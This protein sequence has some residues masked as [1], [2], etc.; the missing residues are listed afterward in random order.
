MH[1]K[2]SCIWKSQNDLQFETEGVVTYYHLYFAK[3]VFLWSAETLKQK[4]VLEEHSQ[5]ITDVR[6]SP[7]T[8]RLA[9]SSFDKTVRVWDVDNVSIQFMFPTFCSDC[10]HMF[11]C[12]SPCLV[13]QHLLNLYMPLLSF[14]SSSWLFHSVQFMLDTVLAG[15]VFSLTQ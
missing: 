12:I 9:T 11:M 4:S 5:L 8:P 14:I 7:S 13:T 6:F 15:Q 3:Q 1:S 2:K 10:V